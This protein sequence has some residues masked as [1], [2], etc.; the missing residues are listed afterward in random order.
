MEIKSYRKDL[1]YSYTLGAFP[2]IELLKKHQKDVIKILVHSSFHNEEVLS[3]IHSL[4]KDTE[5]QINDKLISK[6][7]NKENCYL[8]AVFNKYQMTLNPNKNHI[9]LVN[10]MNMGNFGTIIRSALGFGFTDIAVI[11]PAIDIFDP[12]VLRAAMGS[13]FSSNIVYFNTIEEYK[14]LYPNH[15]LHSFML[16]AKKTLQDKVYGRKIHKPNKF[17]YWLIYTLGKLVYKKKYGMRFNFVDDPR[18]EEGPVIVIANHAS[19]ND[20]LF[21][22]IP[23]YP[24][25]FNF[26]AGYNEFFEDSYTVMEILRAIRQNKNSVCFY[27]EGLSSISGANQP[28]VPGTGKLLKLLKVPVYSVVTKGSYLIM[29]KYK[30]GYKERYAH[31]ETTI[32]KAFSVEDLK[33]MSAEEI[34]SK[35][36]EI[37]YQDDY[38]WAKDNHITYKDNKEG[39]AEGLEGLLFRCPKCGHDFEIETKGNTIKCKHCGNEAYINNDYT[40]HPKSKEDKIPTTQKKW[41]DLERIELRKEIDSNPDYVFEVETTLGVFPKNKLLKFG[42]TALIA[43]KGKLILS[44]KDGFSYIG[45]MNGKPYKMHVPNLNM[46]TFVMCYGPKIIH[47]FYQG[48]LRQFTFAQYGMAAKVLLI[49]NEIHRSVGGKW[50]MLKNFKYDESECFK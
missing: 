35:V 18:K 12:K 7:S 21:V 22:G 33:N 2:T 14:T 11:K 3:L 17:L 34:E 28:S 4:R 47:F 38:E 27:P 32:K 44:K 26:V 24:I 20:Y 5:I 13:F 23:L 39:I 31:T 45:T 8:A 25:R 30:F 50:Q 43:G 1:F 37:L 49:Q 40:I 46:Y 16:Q 36:D 41:F 29:P 42:K 6:L 48:E 15:K 9:V 19:R 10:P